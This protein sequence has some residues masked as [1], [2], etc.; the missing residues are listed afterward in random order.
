[1]GCTGSS[2]GSGG[3]DMSKLTLSQLE[4]L[5]TGELS[6]TA[7][8]ERNGRIFALTNGQSWSEYLLINGLKSQV[9]GSFSGTVIQSDCSPYKLD[10]VLDEATFKPGQVKYGLA[11]N[12]TGTWTYN[13]TDDDGTL[14]YDESTT[15]VVKEG[16][17]F[18]KST[19][20]LKLLESGDVQ[21]I[22]MEQ[23]PY[24]CPRCELTQMWTRIDKTSSVCNACKLSG[25]NDLKSCPGCGTDAF[26]YSVNGGIERCSAPNCRTW[27]S[28]ISENPAPLV[29]FVPMATLKRVK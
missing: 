13:R 9:V 19:I 14:Y 6:V 10:V 18:K 22:A 4:N 16:F 29:P 8:D 28:S 11:K 27:E 21:Y 12:A 23:Y 1:M 15:E 5:P 3:R 17:D 25:S 26:L 2:L 7:L 20:R 24:E